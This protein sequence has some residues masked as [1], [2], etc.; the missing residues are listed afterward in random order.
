[1]WCTCTQMVTWWLGWPVGSTHIN[2]NVEE[3]VCGPARNR[4]RSRKESGQEKSECGG[5]NRPRTNQWYE[6]PVG[7][8]AGGTG[9]RSRV[10]NIIQYST[11]GTNTTRTGRRQKPRDP[12]RVVLWRKVTPQRLPAGRT[13]KCRE[14]N[15]RLTGKDE[16][17][18]HGEFVALSRRVTTRPGKYCIIA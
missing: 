6:K 13:P 2:V 1:M 10:P 4:T 17:G 16:S 3:L 11:L 15:R 14:R 8:Q 9:E 5:R 18:T 7:G 12:C